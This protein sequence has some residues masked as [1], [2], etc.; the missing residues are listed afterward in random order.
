MATIKFFTRTKVSK[1]AP[2]YCRYIDGKKGIDIWIQT[3]FKLFPEFWDVKNQDI[4]KKVIDSGEFFTDEEKNKKF[5]EEDAWDIKAK[6]DDLKRYIQKKAFDVNGN[7]TKNWLQSTIDEFCGVTTTKKDTLNEYI[8]RFIDEAETGKRLA[9]V[10]NKKRRYT[11]GS[12][13]VLTGFMLSFYHYQGM[14]L[15]LKDGKKRRQ[16]TDWGEQTYKP[17]NWEDITIDVYNDFVKYFYGRNCSANYVGKHIKSFKTIMRAAREEGLHNNNVMDLRAFM[18][19]SAPVDQIYLTKEE[20]NRIYKL[21]LSNNKH[22]ADIRDVFLVGCYTAQRYSDYSRINKS[23]IREIQGRKVIEL[24][25]KKTGAKVTIPIGPECDAILKRHDYTLP[26]TFEQKVNDGIKKI[27]AAAEINEMIQQK[28][29]KGGLTVTVNVPKYDLIKTHTARRTGCSLM[30]QDKMPTISIMRIS[31]HRTE[32]EFLKYV[33]LSGEETALSMYDY[34]F[35]GGN[36]L[37]V[38]GKE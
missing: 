5:T 6:F 28:T 16:R 7:V 10:N 1:Y 33:R 19:I 26:K 4:R 37:K 36:N 27:G 15:P 25:Q 35:F 32:S 38:V 14:E 8:K 30:V 20:L 9:T 29:D 21:D 13:R 11:P 2:V 23:M 17:L 18:T 34:S 31:G 12:I 3:E 24:F 22:L